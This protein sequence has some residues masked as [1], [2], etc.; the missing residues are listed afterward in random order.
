MWGY[1]HRLLDFGYSLGAFVALFFVED[2][3]MYATHVLK[4]RCRFFWAAD[5]EVHHSSSEF[6]FTTAFRNSPLAPLSG[7]WLAWPMLCLLGFPPAMVF[8]QASLSRAY[9]CFTHTSTVRRLPAA[10]EWV[11]VTPSHHRV[12]HAKNPAY[13]DKNYGGILII[14][15]RIFGTFQAERDDIPCEFGVLSEFDTSRVGRV[16]FHGLGSMIADIR[17]RRGLAAKL[18]TIIRAPS[19]TPASEGGQTLGTDELR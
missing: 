17:R 12:H 11:F 5:H 10:I 4:H 1:E 18:G 13:I 6:N 16:V 2:F 19:W 14:W 8:F 9:Q 7:A 15:D 3:V